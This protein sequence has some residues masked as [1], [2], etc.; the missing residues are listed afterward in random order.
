MKTSAIPKA[1]TSAIPE[2]EIINPKHSLDNFLVLCYNRLDAERLIFLLEEKG[3][4][5]STG[6]ACAASKGEKSHVLKAIGLTDAQI[7]GSLRI[8][9][10]E[11][12]TK[13]QIINAAKIITETAKEE[14]TRL[15]KQ[16][17]INSQK[18]DA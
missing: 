15:E 13:E 1:K 4:Y 10:G 17:K 12:N 9:F 18:K 16:K 8:S 2:V 11:T 6:A 3:V 7:A 14:Y 5:V